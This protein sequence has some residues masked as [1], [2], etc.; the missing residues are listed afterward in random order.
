MGVTNL[1][2]VFSSAVTLPGEKNGNTFKEFTTMMNRRTL[3][4]ALACALSLSLLTACGGKGNDA[5]TSGSGDLSGQLSDMNDYLKD[6]IS[7]P[8]DLAAAVRR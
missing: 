4:L 2:S 3:S 1:S 6:N 7:K 5:S 8:G